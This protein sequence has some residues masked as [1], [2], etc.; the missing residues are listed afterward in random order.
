MT[1][2][3]KTL[4]A[5]I[6]LAAVFLAPAG[7]SAAN[8]A[9]P[10]NNLGL[11]GYWSFD[12]GAG[13]AASDLSGSGN[14]GTLTNMDSATDWVAGKRGKALDFDGSNDYVTMGD[15]LDMGTGDFT[16]S[17]WVKTTDASGTVRGIVNI[18]VNVFGG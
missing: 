18:I 5:A 2:A 17:V 15:V 4:S 12:D 9:K 11:G 14:A 1:R 16:V 8:L 3:L 10:A 6:A 7:A 13:T